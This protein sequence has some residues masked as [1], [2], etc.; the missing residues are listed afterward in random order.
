M[1]PGISVSLS[2]VTVTDI[3]DEAYASGACQECSLRNHAIFNRCNDS[4][5]KLKPIGKLVK[6]IRAEASAS[7]GLRWICHGGV[8]DILTRG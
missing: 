4:F 5:E 3:R 2:A 7:A 1:A 8:A 6:E